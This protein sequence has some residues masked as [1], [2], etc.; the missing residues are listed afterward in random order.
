MS[1]LTPDRQAE[2]LVRGI[3]AAQFRPGEVF[4]LPPNTTAL[5]PLINGLALSMP[6]TGMPSVYERNW[7]GSD[8]WARVEPKV[9]TAKL[10]RRGHMFNGSIVPETL[11]ILPPHVSRVAHRASIDPADTLSFLILL[12]LNSTGRA[13]FGATEVRGTLYAESKTIKSWRNSVAIKMNLD[14]KPLRGYMS[15]EDLILTSEFAWFRS[16]VGSVRHPFQGGE[17]DNS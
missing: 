15:I 5:D 2:L 1:Q 3:Q 13:N 17:M 4:D 11:T 12:R 8:L 16:V 14:V 9:R 10:N 7:R 6:F